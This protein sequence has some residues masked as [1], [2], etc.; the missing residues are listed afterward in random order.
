VRVEGVPVLNAAFWASSMHQGNLWEGT[1]GLVLLSCRPCH[2]DTPRGSQDCEAGPGLRLV[3]GSRSSRTCWHHSASTM[4][5]VP[6]SGPPCWPARES[7]GVWSAASTGRWQAAAV[8]LIWQIRGLA[9]CLCKVAVSTVRWPPHGAMAFAVVTARVT[10]RLILHI[11]QVH[12][13]FLHPS[14]FA[15][16]TFVMCLQPA[17]G[18][19]SLLVCTS[20]PSG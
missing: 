3:R 10:R 1:S 6:V 18:F 2:V 14:C 12:D 15:T 5:L 19:L 9:T 8:S 16:Q 7:G 4:V 11:Q 20:Y 13:T 17:V